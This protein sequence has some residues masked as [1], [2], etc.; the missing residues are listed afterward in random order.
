[1][2]FVHEETINQWIEKY[3][4]PNIFAQ[5]FE[6]MVTEQLDLIA[7][8]NQDNLS[9]LT[10]EELTLLEYLTLIIYQSSKTTLG[11][12]PLI[13]GQK[14]EENE[15]NNWDIWNNLTTKSLKFAFDK[16]FES[17]PQEDLLAL[18]EDSLQQDEENIVT[19]VGCE[20]IAVACKSIID[21]IHKEN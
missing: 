15:E 21:T 2:V 6:K 7:Y 18:V 12:N 1:M 9:L 14:I 11:K 8:I 17:Y 20:I 3:E 13:L 4:D 10:Q 19:N 5:D 16:Y